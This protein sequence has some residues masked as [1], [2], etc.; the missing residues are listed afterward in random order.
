M[1]GYATEGRAT[2]EVGIPAEQRVRIVSVSGTKVKVE[3]V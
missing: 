2:A 3:P 1:T